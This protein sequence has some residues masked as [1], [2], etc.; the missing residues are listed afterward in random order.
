M[1]K[2]TSIIVKKTTDTLPSAYDINLKEIRSPFFIFKPDKI[3]ENVE[4]FVNNFPGKSLYAVKTNPSKFVLKT[5]YKFG[6]KSFDVAS[7][8]EIKLIKNLFKN[9]MIYFMNP[10]K[11]RY[12]IKEAYFN[13]G[14]KH[15]SLDSFDELKKITESTNFPKDL[16]LH[17]RISIPNDFAEI[18]LSKKFGVNGNEAKILLKKIKD[19]SRKIGVCFHPGSQCMDTNAYKFAINKSDL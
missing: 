19:F 11:P 3:K 8:N 4:N 18:K 7:I 12:A 15:F 6:I 14:I 13:Y 2:K 5:I 9:A 1:N 16:N 10:V 17:L